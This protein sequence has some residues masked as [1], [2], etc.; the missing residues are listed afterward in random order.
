L[1][2]GAGVM[3]LPLRRV[4]E[5]VWMI[6]KEAK[7]CMKVPVIIYADDFLINKMR[8]DLTLVQAMNVAC[9]RGI[10]KY[11]LVMPDGH[12]GYGFPVGGWRRWL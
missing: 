3:T 9:L 8:E 10:Q 12:Q 4:N 11:S 1:K 2:Q 5:N 6:P 7:A